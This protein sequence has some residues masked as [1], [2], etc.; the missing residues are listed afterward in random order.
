MPRQPCPKCGRLLFPVQGA[1]HCLRCNVRFGK[2]EEKK[3]KVTEKD[4]DFLKKAKVKW[5]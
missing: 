4:R 2:T 1:Y 5:E 3:E